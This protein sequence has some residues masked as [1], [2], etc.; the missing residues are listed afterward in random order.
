MKPYVPINTINAANSVYRDCNNITSVNLDYIA[1]VD[2]SMQ[3]A[4]QNCSN[5]STV[6]NINTAVTNMYGTFTNCPI[7][8]TPPTLPSSVQN[9]EN[10]FSECSNLTSAPTIPSSVKNMWGTFY[11]C[12]NLTTAPTIPSGVTNMGSTFDECRNLTTAPATIPDSVTQMY[13]TF[14]N[15][16]N[17]VTAPIISNSV[18]NMSITF[19][20]CVN[21]T[22]TITI[23]S[24]QVANAQS[25]FTYTS[26]AKTVYIP[27]YNLYTNKETAITYVSFSA[28]GYTP[29][30]TKDGVTIK[31]LTPALTV[32]PT[33]SDATVI[34]GCQGHS[35]TAK[36]IAVPLN[37][38]VSWYVSKTGYIPKNGSVS[39]LTADQSISVTLDPSVSSDWEFN[40]DDSDLAIVTESNN[41]GNNLAVPDQVQGV[42]ND[43]NAGAVTDT[44][45]V[46]TIDAGT[47]TDTTIDA[48]GDAGSIV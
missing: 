18:T 30:D 12:Y 34:L 13:A 5:L 7:M 19:C 21:L 9:L 40:V 20:N 2:A 3:T 35:I 15:C 11:K 32:N 4:F 33:P 16:S 8:V 14:W 28:A 43:N 1:W 17:L 42:P 23:H 44:T 10:T 48:D 29:I 41:N 45:I 39:M 31:N 25:C 6:T 27:Y 36:S 38:T 47:V 22:G 46:S 26:K 24:N 37:E